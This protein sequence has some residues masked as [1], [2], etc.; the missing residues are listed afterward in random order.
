MARRKYDKAE[1]AIWLKGYFYAFRKMKK[2]KSKTQYS[3]SKYELPQKSVKEEKPKYL[4]MQNQVIKP[5]HKFVPPPEPP[6]LH[7]FLAFNDNGDMFNVFAYGETREKAL[8]YAREKLKRDPERPCWG[9]H[10][11]ESKAN[12]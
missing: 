4:L 8:R 1:K 6:D 5:K 9:V 10:I 2:S 11:T 7:K 12:E 3:T